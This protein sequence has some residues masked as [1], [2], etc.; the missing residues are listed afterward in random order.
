MALTYSWKQLV[1]RIQIQILNDFP[2]S[3]STMTDNQILLYVNEAMSSGLV[4]QV[5]GGA[6][7]LGTLEVPDAYIIRFQLAALSKDTA[8]GYWTTSLPQPP[9]SLPLGYSINRIYFANS[10]DGVGQDV[11]LIKAKR[12]GRRTDMPM[13]FG[14]RAWVTGG[15]LWMAAS[16]GSSLLNQ[17]CYIEMPST[18]AVNITDTMPLPDDAAEAIMTKV[19]ARLKERLQMPQ[20][21]ILDDTPTGNKNG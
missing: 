14:V 1:E 15:T 12:V 17:N 3:E 9:V 20:E 10:V 2:S 6:K 16:N 4:G 5:Y 13:Q 7:I 19:V 11:A 18:R 8:T 21:N